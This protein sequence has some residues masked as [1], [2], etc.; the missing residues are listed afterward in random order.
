MTDSTA[1]H[2]AVD[3]CRRGDDVVVVAVHGELDVATVPRLHERLCRLPGHT[4]ELDLAGVQF[5]DPAGLRGLLASA[6]ELARHG[7]PVRYVAVSGAVRRLLEL[8][9]SHTRLRV[10]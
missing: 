2:L 7:R 9:R 5:I 4:V 8:T 1:L 10:D 6:E 3:T